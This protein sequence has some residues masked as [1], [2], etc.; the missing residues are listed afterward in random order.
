MG[1]GVRNGTAKGSG[2]VEERTPSTE[3]REV[4]FLGSQRTDGP[5]VYWLRLQGEMAGLMAA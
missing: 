5:R 2:Q 1:A 3:A 4:T